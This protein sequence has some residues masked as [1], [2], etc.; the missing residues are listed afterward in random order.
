MSSHTFSVPVSVVLK[1]QGQFR[2]ESGA[3]NATVQGLPVTSSAD[4]FVQAKMEMQAALENFI[5]SR[6]NDS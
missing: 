2:L 5:Y 1:F 3:W 4:G 6:L